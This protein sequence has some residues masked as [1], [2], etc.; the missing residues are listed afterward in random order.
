MTCSKLQP[1]STLQ[2][3]S[4]NI[5]H[6]SPL[7]R[8]PSTPAWCCHV[9][10]THL[11]FFLY[12]EFDEDKHSDFFEFQCNSHENNIFL[13]RKDCM[14]LTCSRTLLYVMFHEDIV[15]H[16]YLIAPW[17]RVQNCG[18]RIHPNDNPRH[19][20]L[21]SHTSQCKAYLTLV[22]LA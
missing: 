12:D 2:D 17:T 19:Y 3:E 11:Q 15:W 18:Q 8:V 10:A 20:A 4:G 22:F 5:L 7:W 9:T 6:T 21:T 14:E 1:D 16:H 13:I